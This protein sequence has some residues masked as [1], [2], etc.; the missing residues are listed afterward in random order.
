MALTNE[1]IAKFARSRGLAGKKREEIFSGGT[2]SDIIDVLQVPQ[3]AL[4]GLISGKGAIT[5]I[6]ER[7]T[8]SKELGL[9]GIPGFAADVILDPIT[10]T[11]IGAAVKA[12]K[13]AKGVSAAR[14]AAT[15]AE[16][17]KKGERALITAFGK[18]VLKGQKVFEGLT[19]AGEVIRRS[20]VGQ[21]LRRAFDIRPAAPK[22][23]TLKQV[24]DLAVDFRKIREAGL[25]AKAV[26]RKALG[27]AIDV[28][29]IIGKKLDN[30][31]NTKVIQK[32]D[33][34]E[35][36]RAVVNKINNIKPVK[37]FPK[38]IDELINTMEETV[39]KQQ[40]IRKDLGLPELEA[41]ALPL[42]PVEESKEFLKSQK[43]TGA[44]ARKFGGTDPSTLMATHFKVGDNVVKGKDIAE[45]I[46]A[47]GQPARKFF[48]VGNNYF[49]KTAALS[50]ES[51]K[52]IKQVN[53]IID[54]DIIPRKMQTVQDLESALEQRGIALTDTSRIQLGNLMVN[55]LRRT[56]VQA[57]EINT[58][59]NKAGKS[60]RFS[61]DPT[62]L[63][64]ELIARTGRSSAKKKF[65]TEAGSVG[66]PIPKDGKIPEGFRESTLKELKGLI[67]PDPLVDHI[68][69]THKAFSNI[70]EVND[71]VKVYDKV[72][73]T[74]KGIVTFVNPAFHSRNFVSN[75]WQGF[76]AGVKNPKR[77]VD[78]GIIQKKVAR[79]IKKGDDLVDVLSPEEHKLWTEFTEQGLGGTGWIGT[80]IERELKANR[81]IVFDKAGSV[82]SY[83]ED[84]AKLGVFM[85]MKKKG[86][87]TEEA[88]AEVR[89]FLFDYSD[90]TDFERN[91][92]KRIFPFYTWSRNNIPLQV[93]MLIQQPGKFSAIGKARDNIERSIEDEPM[94]ER[95]IPEWLREGYP[96]FFGRNQKNLARYFKLEGFL[97]SVDITN[98]GDPTELA[99]NLTSPLIKAPFEL[100]G[101]RNLFFKRDIEE[102][103]GQVKPF[104]LFGF[105]VSAK[106][107]YFAR[108]I[109]PLVEMDKLFEEDL[110]LG[111]RATKF[112]TGAKFQELDERK[113]RRVFEYLKGLEKSKRKKQIERER[114][115]G[116]AFNIPALR[117][118]LGRRQRE[119]RL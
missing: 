111:E 50:S 53:K 37:K 76:L 47:K 91:V 5:G 12:P 20:K 115:E 43:A 58:V 48:R 35:I 65:V 15:L 112:L 1:Q 93:A 86:L 26:E 66:V 32:G 59:L 9:K 23:A 27:D 98:I 67:F 113:Q 89:K 18:P 63:V 7:V 51:E 24:E 29:R 77:Y 79:A 69:A 81:N 8:P 38:A 108:N 106:T 36:L 118:E 19:K 49:E 88:A 22:G 56:A 52:I 30:L 2:L 14:R 94:D 4:T 114:K 17:A 96:I 16:Q 87:A 119:F 90:L 6:K 3:T 97:P 116:R 102:F 34:A 61:E 25:K 101:N 39:K 95:F 44:S 60:L 45:T 68:D 99:V 109:R 21:G 10:F 72:Q 83:I 54:Q 103:P 110:T 107:E 70:D 100:A 71:F 28:G 104:P 13:A 78:A 80:D 75:L 64:S 117:E 40:G 41:K 62:V 42:I 92:M 73:N 82:G 84:N 105:N 11:G 74:W 57:D 33:R 31:E 55:A 46:V 85:D